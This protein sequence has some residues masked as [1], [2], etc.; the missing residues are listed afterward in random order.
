MELMEIRRRLMAQMASG[1]RYKSGTVT[2]DA[3]ATEIIING[4]PFVP[5]FAVICIRGDMDFSAYKTF[6]QGFFTTSAINR[7]L[8][9][10]CIMI[11]YDAS[12]TSDAPRLTQSYTAQIPFE[13]GTLTF[14]PRGQSF[15]FAAGTYEYTIVE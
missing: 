7:L 5:S 6:Y 15:P 11:R 4:I 1:K 3:S 2:L 9:T 8:S 12:G 10:G 14:T 13:N